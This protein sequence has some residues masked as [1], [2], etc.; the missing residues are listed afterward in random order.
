MFPPKFAQRIVGFFSRFDQTGSMLHSIE[1]EYNEIYSARG[2]THA[3]IWFW[4]Q[5]FKSI[6]NFIKFSIYWGLAMLTSYFKTALRSI[7]KQK[8]YA[9]INIAGLAVGLAAVILIM[10]WVQNEL[11]Y[12]NFYKDNGNIYRVLV[13]RTIDGKTFAE[14]DTPYLIADEIKDKVP[15]VE[16][17][18]TYLRLPRFV[19]KSGDKKFYEDGIRAGGV[20]F[21]SIFSCN[22]IEGNASTVLNS[23]GSIVIS[24]STA[25]KYFGTTQALGKIMEIDGSAFSVT[26]IFEDMPQNSHLKFDMVID[27]YYIETNYRVM[28]T[29]DNFSSRNYVKLRAGSNMLVT[30]DEINSTILQN[31]NPEDIAKVK[32]KFVLQPLKDIYLTPAIMKYIYIFSLL[33]LL[34]LFIASMNY[35]NLS[36]AISLK[37]LKEVGIRK[38]VGSNRSQL[39]YQFLVETIV[40]TIIA[41]FLAVLIDYLLLPIFN[42]L[43]GK[44][45]TINFLSFNFI[46]TMLAV[47]VLTSLLAGSYPAFYVSSFQPVKILKGSI[48]SGSKSNRFRR[49]LVIS[50][51]TISIGMIICTLIVSDQVSFLKNKDLGFEKDHVVYIPLAGELKDKYELLQN[52][53]TANPNIEGVTASMYL[54]TSRGR[55][56]GD[57][58]WTGKDPAQRAMAEMPRIDYNF[59][60]LLGLD[61]VDGRNFSKEFT[62]DADEAVIINQEMAKQMH[63]PSPVGQEISYNSK[64]GRIVGIVKDAN[65]LPLQYNIEPQVF[66]LLTDM[67]STVRAVILIKLNETSGSELTQTI[68]FIEDTWNKFNPNQP[69]EFHFWNNSM[70][71]LYNSEQTISKLFSYFA[72]LAIMI[73][74]LGLFGLASLIVEQKRKEIGIR[75]SIGASVTSLVYMLIKK[76]FTWILFANIIAWPVAYYVMSEWLND[77]AYRI[78]LTLWTFIIAGAAALAI[79]VIAVGYQS[80]KAS[81]ANPIDSLR[82]E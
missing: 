7:I 51:Y 75:K 80:V 61:I 42:E 25:V 39:I 58:E 55:N 82:T 38:V 45:I 81:Q 21:F 66:S 72:I 34:I 67:S 48:Y 77:F 60:S 76:F 33:A 79:A 74:C 68:S 57:V 56:R 50:Q 20:D 24:K 12:D 65:F 49:L 52:E 44:A 46:A 53:L 26:G 18:S 10:F 1:E 30:D 43:V 47:I 73:S 22:F 70:E 17:S 4:K 9:L 32:R 27:S 69:F 28:L 78:D 40:I 64:T 36:T 19:V 16:Y 2:K 31:Y 5:T 35:V 54:P 41:S 11:S 6:P 3:D 63:I 14:A 23:P 8:E 59:F 62:T 71:E 29:W 15:G 37:R 13:Q